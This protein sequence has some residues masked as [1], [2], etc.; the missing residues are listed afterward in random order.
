MQFINTKP[1][2]RAQRLD[3]AVTTKSIAITHGMGVPPVVLYKP[4]DTAKKTVTLDVV[5]NADNTA[6]TYES[7]VALVGTIY[8]S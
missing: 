4:T 2:A 3:F 6:F 5:N 8:V 1:F 7:V